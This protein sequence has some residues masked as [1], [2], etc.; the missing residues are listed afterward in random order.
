VHIN[1]PFFSGICHYLNHI[2]EIGRE[3]TILMMMRRRS[4]AT[5]ERIMMMSDQSTVNGIYGTISCY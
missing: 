4:T 5:T 2:V 3:M 1:L